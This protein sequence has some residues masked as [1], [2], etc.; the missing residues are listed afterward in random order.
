[1]RL[2]LLFLL[3]ATP[4]VAQVNP[5]SKWY[6]VGIMQGKYAGGVH[7]I[8]ICIVEG[9]RCTNVAMGGWLRVVN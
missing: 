1:M 4:S 3:L 6:W 7:K 8:A 2:L 9:T 5:S